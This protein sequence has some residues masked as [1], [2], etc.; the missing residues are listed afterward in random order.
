M[1]KF[2]W[3]HNAMLGPM[4]SILHDDSVFG[5]TGEK[6]L[7]ILQKHDITVEEAGKPLDFLSIQYPY[8]RKCTCSPDTPSQLC[9]RYVKQECNGYEG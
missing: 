5:V 7:G 4:P 2:V 9:E 6:D 1:P 8:K 3:L